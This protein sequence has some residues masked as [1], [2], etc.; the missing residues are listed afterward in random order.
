MLFSFSRVK[1]CSL[2]LL[3]NVLLFQAHVYTT[4]SGECAAFLSNYDSKSSVRVLFN[5]MHYSLPPWSVSILPDCRNVV[6]NTA[7]VCNKSLAY[8]VSC[9]VFSYSIHPSDD[10]FCA[11]NVS[12]QHDLVTE[13]L[14]KPMNSCFF[15]LG[16]SANI[17]DANVADKYSIVLM[18]KF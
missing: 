16:W 5:N 17:S 7:K 12:N 15:C 1:L 18:G 14:F 13:N 4:E 11:F 10:N 8:L 3:A 2:I 6:F 9:I